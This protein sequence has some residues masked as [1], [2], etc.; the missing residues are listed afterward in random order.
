MQVSRLVAY[1]LLLLVAVACL[2]AAWFLRG[3]G[4]TTISVAL[5]AGL[6]LAG[7]AAGARAWAT[8]STAPERFVYGH[9]GWT[10]EQDRG[11]VDKTCIPSR[12]LQ[13][14]GRDWPLQRVGYVTWIS[15]DMHGSVSAFPRG[16]PVFRSPDTTQ[17][18]VRVRPGCY[19]VYEDV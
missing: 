1:G 3:R 13:R 18:F 19:A 16:L 4:R 6:R 9:A 2:L 12:A 8:T 5:V 11:S 15:F 17:L 7:V 10:L 14:S